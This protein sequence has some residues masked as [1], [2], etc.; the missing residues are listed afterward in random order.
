MLAYLLVLLLCARM[1][2]DIAYSGP[3]PLLALVL[4]SSATVALSLF[5]FVESKTIAGR[6][7]IGVAVFLGL[8]LAASTLRSDVGL[9]SHLNFAM[10][11]FLPA[12]F[13]LSCT[14]RP[15][16]VQKAALLIRKFIAIPVLGLV[17][18]YAVLDYKANNEFGLGFF[19]YYANH[20]N[21]LI[22]QTTMKLSMLFLGG[23]LW[24]A[25][26]GFV[27]LGVLNV[28]SALVAFIVAYLL[29]YKRTLFRWEV[30]KRL[31]PA[32]AIAVPLAWWFLDWNSLVERFLYR[33][34]SH[35]GF[36]SIYNLSSGR[37]E[38][39]ASYL[40]YISDRFD[41]VDWVL[42]KGPVWIVDSE[43]AL[44]A[45]N[46]LLNLFTAFGLLGLGATAYAYYRFFET[47]STSIRAAGIA[48]FLALFLLNGVVFHQSTMLFA[49]LY[50]Y[51]PIRSAR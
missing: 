7:N 21:H 18:Y 42:G 33:D 29:F 24:K 8:T 26:C 30:M 37:T 11:V 12:M 19:D 16:D 1:A 2:I 48:A 41:V 3:K 25:V 38:I 22:A 45:H 5:M 27:L 23:E 49:L 51:D 14:A 13:L 43:I 4:L 28:R 9:A 31:F 32:L 10:Q 39:Y 40:Y 36:E 34:R 44:S 15:R 35:Y 50:V 46:D 47:L 6:K 20:P 17:V